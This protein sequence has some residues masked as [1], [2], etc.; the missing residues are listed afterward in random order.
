MYWE[1][2]RQEEKAH[3]V[4]D[5]VDLV[6]GI[7]CKCLPVDHVHTLSES[8]QKVLPWIS[9]EPAAGVHSIHV[10]ASGNGW[11]RPDDPDALLHLSRRT[12]LELRVPKHR[13][14]DA[15]QL[16]GETL[17]VNGFLIEVM[18]ATVRPLSTI[19]TVF[20]RYLA[21]DDN[22]EDEE[23]VL[24][25]VAEQLKGLD[26]RPRKMLCGTAHY[27][28]TPEG[29]ITTRS[30]MLSDLEV[31]ES[32]RLQERGIGPYRNM[33]CGLFIPHKDI[34]DIREKKE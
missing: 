30:L 27:I 29:K 14:D 31:E 34:H 20:S 10:A 12:R 8:V 3:V 19:T 4:D 16:E 33:G 1:E 23:Q 25:W 13:I 5:V 24:E 2:E 18:E 26:I 6:F 17:D 21:T 15:R 32:I 22:L 11:M 7:Q 9:D 28:D